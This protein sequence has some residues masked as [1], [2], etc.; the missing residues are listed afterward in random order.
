MRGF[1]HINGVENQ[2]KPFSKSPLQIR[3]P[4]DPL[5]NIGDGVGDKV[6]PEQSGISAKRAKK[7]MGC[8]KKASERARVRGVSVTGEGRSEEKIRVVNPR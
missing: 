6:W 8:A 5:H 3:L 4:A 7:A 1:S 2:S